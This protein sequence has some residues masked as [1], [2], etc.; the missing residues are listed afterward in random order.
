MRSHGRLLCVLTSAAILLAAPAQG[1]AETPTTVVEI[2]VAGNQRLTKRAVLA[3]VRT[4]VGQPY[5]QAVVKEDRRRLFQSGLFDSVVATRTDTDQGVIVTFVVI[6]RPLVAEVSFVGNKAFKDAQLTKELS[7]GTSTP[8]NLFAVRFGQQA[9]LNKYHKRGYHK[10][11]VTYDQTA[12]WQ[13]KTLTFRTHVA[14]RDRSAA[15]QLRSRC[16]RSSRVF[17]KFSGRDP[18]LATDK[19][20]CMV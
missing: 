16:G 5:E 13:N 10:A 7:F 8:V 9:I 1:Q 17:A 19:R 18:A 20:G 2:H 6:E 11:Q 12:K 15:S 4:R 3:H 14:T